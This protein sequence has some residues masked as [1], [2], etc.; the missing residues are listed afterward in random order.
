M[1]MYVCTCILDEQ[2]IIYKIKQYKTIFLFHQSGMPSPRVYLEAIDEE[3]SFPTSSTT[4]GM[5]PVQIGLVIINMYQNNNI[6]TQS[7]L[8][9]Y[10]IQQNNNYVQHSPQCNNYYNKRILVLNVTQSHNPVQHDTSRYMSM[11][12]RASYL[13]RGRRVPECKAYVLPD[14][15][16]ECQPSKPSV[17]SLF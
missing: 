11:F 4:R 17:Q 9:H 6:G 5:E 8:H 3:T 10:C 2:V 12:S 14:I 16:K 13:G 7:S 15:P 1:H